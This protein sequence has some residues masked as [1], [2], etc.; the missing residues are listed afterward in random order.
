MLALVGLSTVCV[1]QGL[2]TPCEPELPT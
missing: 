2:F 1:H